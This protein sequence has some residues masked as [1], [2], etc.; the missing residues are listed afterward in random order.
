MRFE[1]PE[2]NLS[3]HAREEQK[4]KKIF[5]NMYIFKMANLQF[6]MIYE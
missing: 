5:T 3:A 2:P 4:K 6:D 1:T